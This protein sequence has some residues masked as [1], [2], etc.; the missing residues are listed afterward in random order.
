MTE[1]PKVPFLRQSGPQFVGPDGQLVRPRAFM[2]YCQHPGC[3]AWGAFGFKVRLQAKNQPG[4]WY[5]AEHKADG[6]A[7]YQKP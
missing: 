6:L 3:T 7:L 2:H 1:T 4:V 5:C